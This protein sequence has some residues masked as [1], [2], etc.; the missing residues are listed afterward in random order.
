LFSLE[1]IWGKNS[2]TI[3]KRI[4]QILASVLTAALVLAASATTP[5]AP[6]TSSNIRPTLF[7]VGDSTVKNGSGHGDGGLWGW[8]Q[9]LAPLFDSDRITVKNEAI[10]GRSSR[11]FFTEG[12]WDRVVAELRPGDFVLMQ[13]GHND[14]GELFKGNRPRASLKGN[15]DETR[16]GVVEATGKSE[17][18]HSYGWYLRRY[19]ADAKAQGATPIV[20]SP[21]PRNIWK[22]GHVARASRDYGKWAAAAAAAGGAE[23][24][25]LNEIIARRYEQAG[26]DRVKNDYF[27]SA[28]HTH[29]TEAGAQVNAKC[30]AAGLRDSASP[31]AKFLIEVDAQSAPA[32]DSR[33]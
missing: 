22:D 29:T 28:D 23:F 1:F 7:L 2:M 3:T 12:R 8:G 32:S 30:V 21:V 9:V 27:T 25:D 15:G 5:G 6:A 19:I 16:D 17:T 24:V 26:E 31:L 33:Q 14:G 20:L 13:F 10:G 4:S 11:T 18:V